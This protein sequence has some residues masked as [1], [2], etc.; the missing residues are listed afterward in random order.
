MRSRAEGGFFSVAAALLLGYLNPTVSWSPDGRWLA[1]TVA[2]RPGE[3]VLPAGWLFDTATGSESERLGWAKPAERRE[4][5]S[6]RL[7]TTRSDGAVSVLLEESA[8]PLTSPAWSPDGNALAFGRLVAEGNGRSRFEV[9]VQDAPDRKRVVLKQPAADLGARAAELP[10]LTLAWSPD[11]RYLAVPVLQPA[12][13]LAILRADTGRILKVLEDAYLPSWSSDS[14]KLAFVTG[15]EAVSLDFLDT[16]FGRSRHLANIGQPCQ[17]PVWSKDKRFV[18]IVAQGRLRPGMRFPGS[19]AELVR[20]PIDGGQTEVLALANTIFRRDRPSPG[21]SFA[22]DQ[23]A[24][25]LFYTGDS[26]GEQSEIVWYQ[27]RDRVTQRK[28]N[29]IDPTV[30]LGSLSV[31]PGML[32]L[33]FRAGGGTQ[34]AAPPGLWDAKT[35]RFT[36]VVPDDSARLE[37]VAT[38]VASARRLLL[39]TLPPATG[40][41]GRRVERATLLPVPS[42]IGQNQEIAFRLRRVALTGQALCTRP[43]S[44]HQADPLV[45]AQLDEARLFFEFLAGDYVMALKALESLEAQT[46]SPDHRLRLMSVRAQIYVGQRQEELARQTI[47]FLQSLEGRAP[48]RYEETPAG[49]ALTIEGTAAEGWPTYLAARADEW[50]KVPGDAA[51]DALGRPQPG[52]PEPVFPFGQMNL[53]ELRKDDADVEIRLGP[54]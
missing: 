25:H 17:A 26:H 24:D 44:A 4:F 5:A 51:S 34:P 53:L 54:R 2:V 8:G 22:F 12:V 33:A 49:P 37:W 10:S 39:G 47:R 40:V 14:T 15:T 27:P 1:Y 6:Y 46:E 52:A 35:L 3:R 16:S 9:V 18:L 11:R 45:R 28:S 20:V 36:A 43:A 50:F 30:R 41:G 32:N 38:L 31:S 42:E 13:G 19:G 48:R 23:E 21:I 29:P 7:W